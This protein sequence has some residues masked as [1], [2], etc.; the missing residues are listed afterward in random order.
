MEEKEVIR[1]KKSLENVILVWIMFTIIGIFIAAGVHNSY[2]WGQGDYFGAKIYA[3]FAFLPFLILDVMTYYYLYAVDIVVT[4]MRVY[5]K[6][7]FGRRVELPLDSISA[8][9]LS[10]WSGIDVGTSSGKIH[11]KNI[12]NNNEVLTEISKLINNRQS[13][14]KEAENNV[15]IPEELK[16][17]KELLDSGVIT[18]EEFEAKKKQLLNL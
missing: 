7:T 3:F 9:G 14:T 2:A 10:F 16:K 15:S 12:S 11:F 4:N 17:Y 8:V 13:K 6:A 18:Q 1:G 5:G